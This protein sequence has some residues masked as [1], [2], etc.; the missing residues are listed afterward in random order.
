MKS[1]R[2]DLNA[3]TKDVDKMKNE[4]ADIRKQSKSTNEYVNTEM[5]KLREEIKLKNTAS[6]NAK[7]ND[8]NADNV[9]LSATVTGFA[10]DTPK[11]NILSTLENMTNNTEIDSV[12]SPKPFNK[13]GFIKF[14]TAEAKQAFMT[15]YKND[16]DKPKVDGKDLKVS[17]TMTPLQLRRT[18]KSWLLKTVIEKKKTGFDKHIKV[19]TCPGMC[20]VWIDGKRVAQMPNDEIKLNIK[21]DVVDSLNIGMSGAEL[22]EAYDKAA[23][24]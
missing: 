11:E 14:K 5:V 8:P 13:V 9:K 7:Q 10:F 16:E 19:Y 17:H 12:Y 3:V 6:I 18:Y 4:I 23:M 21:E 20:I 1:I 24:D 15:E 22:R 2:K